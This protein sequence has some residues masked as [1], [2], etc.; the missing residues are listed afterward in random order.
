[1]AK[2]FDIGKLVDIVPGGNTGQESIF[3]G[4][5][6][7]KGLSRD[8]K[9]IV[10]IHDGVR[11]LINGEL[12]SNCSERVKKYGNAITTTPAIETVFVNEDDR[13]VGEIF[14]RSRC[15]MARA[16][17]CFYLQD[18]YA[19]HMK[20]RQEK[21]DDFIDSAMLMQHYGAKLHT[22]DGPVANIIWNKA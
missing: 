8:S 9:D 21:K 4:L 19:A 1:M 10:L 22:V 14:N 3:H 12:I 2:K 16:P 5:Q 6:K 7:V 18:I 13:N 17:Q 20:A 15:A 11:P